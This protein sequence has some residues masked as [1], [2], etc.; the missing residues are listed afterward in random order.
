[1]S[2]MV[3][4]RHNVPQKNVQRVSGIVDRWVAPA[5]YAAN[6]Q[7]LIHGNP[8]PLTPFRKLFCMR[9]VPPNVYVLVDIVFSY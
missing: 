3:Y 6:W 4:T 2:V 5:P 1:M 7:G 9:A 8:S